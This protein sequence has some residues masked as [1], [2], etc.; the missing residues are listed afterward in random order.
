[1]PITLGGTGA[2]N[3]ADANKNLGS[4][5]TRLNITNAGIPGTPTGAFELNPEH[6]AGGNG[7]PFNGNYSCVLTLAEGGTNPTGNWFQIAVNRNVVSPPRYRYRTNAPAAISN[8]YSFRTEQNTTVDS[9]GF[10]KTASPI[11]KLFGSGKFE[12]N[13]ESE[14]VSVKKIGTGEYLL[15]GCKGLNADAA[16][17]G[18]DG[19]F[20]V[21]ADRNKQPLIWLDYEVNADGSVLVRTFHRTYPSAPL[22]AR[23]EI[24]GLEDGQPADIPADQFVSIRVQMPNAAAGSDITLEEVFLS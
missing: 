7:H 1:M 15:E 11:V 12:T 20:E 9:N 22:F 16:W 24:K 21:P 6:T 19:G 2:K 3:V 4:F 14:G 13:E 8:W 5:N 10:I 18:I 17:G 23:N